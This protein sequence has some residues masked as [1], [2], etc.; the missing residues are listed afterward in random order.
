MMGN[1]DTDR[2]EK[3]LRAEAGGL[4]AGGAAQALQCCNQSS[5]PAGTQD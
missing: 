1:S 5:S 3:C 2:S 4:E